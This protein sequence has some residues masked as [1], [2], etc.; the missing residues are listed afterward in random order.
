M[1]L[2]DLHDQ[3][4]FRWDVRRRGIVQCFVEVLYAHFSAGWGRQLS[5]TDQGTYLFQHEMQWR[6]ICSNHR[7]SLRKD[8]LPAMS[9]H[10]LII[11]VFHTHIKRIHK[12]NSL[13]VFVLTML[14]VSLPLS[15][16]KSLYFNV[17]KDECTLYRELTILFFYEK[18]EPQN[19]QIAVVFLSLP[20]AQ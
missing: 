16:P 3:N 12:A 13:K 6:I 20:Q 8:R 18:K 11:F 4:L 15:D 9:H 7:Y 17:L 10:M 2:C 14:I 5:S 1:N 19:I